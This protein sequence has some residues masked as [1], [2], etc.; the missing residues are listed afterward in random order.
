MKNR[1]VL[2][3]ENARGVL[4]MPYPVRGVS[5]QE[6]G[7]EGYLCPA[8]EG[9][10]GRRYSCPGPWG[11]EGP[12]DTPVLPT[13]PPGQNQN[14]GTPSP[15]RK[16]LGLEAGYPPLPWTDTHLWKHNLPSYYVDS[17][18][19]CKEYFV[20]FSIFVW[21]NFIKTQLPDSKF[22]IL[23]YFPWNSIS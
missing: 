17:E 7:A 1:K 15:P 22:W 18:I 20:D 14:R 8:G 16:D 10:E 5:C 12:G 13:P 11:G 21:K 3:R 6:Q 2:L 23:I 9:W 19:H 4:P